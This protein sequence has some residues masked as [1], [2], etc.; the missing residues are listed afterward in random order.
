MKMKKILFD[1]DFKCS[2]IQ[3][4]SERVRTIQD[5]TDL[6]SAKEKKNQRTEVYN[7]LGRMVFF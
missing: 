2:F 5:V 1:F 7:E 3:N 4:E 6:N